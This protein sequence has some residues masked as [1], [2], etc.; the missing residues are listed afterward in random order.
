[1]STWD[2]QVFAETHQE[3]WLKEKNKAKYVMSHKNAIKY[4]YIWYNGTVNSIKCDFNS[5]ESS[6]DLI[7]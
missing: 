7:P 5:L 6:N 1:M 3:E 2:Y 4:L